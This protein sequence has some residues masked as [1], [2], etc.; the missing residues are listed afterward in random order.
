MQVRAD[1]VFFEE[2]E[3]SHAGT[4]RVRPARDVV[5]APCFGCGSCVEGR[6]KGVLITKV[7]AQAPFEALHVG[8]MVRL[9]RPR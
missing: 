6:G 7:V 1:D 8:V 9:P 5:E 2:F 4:D 3:G